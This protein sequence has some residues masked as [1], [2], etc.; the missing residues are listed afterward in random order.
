[1]TQEI[2]KIEA[3]IRERILTDKPLLNFWLNFFILNWVTSGIM[4]LV[5]YFQRIGRVDKFVL[6]RRH[7]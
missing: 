6:R 1:M 3:N 4:G 5:L 2:H 7:F